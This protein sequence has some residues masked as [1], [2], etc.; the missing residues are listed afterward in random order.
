MG[1]E[2]GR[3]AVSRDQRTGWL[4][5]HNAVQQSR[6]VPCDLELN[7]AANFTQDRIS[8]YGLDS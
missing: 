8:N 5:A 6:W 3:V 2:A 7:F 1:R 4:V